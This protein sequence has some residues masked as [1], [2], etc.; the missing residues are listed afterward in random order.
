MLGR[1][2]ICSGVVKDN[3]YALWVRSGCNPSDLSLVVGACSV[4]SLK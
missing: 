1:R 2:N 3:E 4:S